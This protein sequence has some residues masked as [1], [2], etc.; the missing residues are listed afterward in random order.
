M[1]NHAKIMFVR[2]V[3]KSNEFK[4]SAFVRFKSKDDVDRLFEMN[5]KI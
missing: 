3:K 2:F 1:K 4:G 5:E